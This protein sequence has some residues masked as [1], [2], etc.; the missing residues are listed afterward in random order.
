MIEAVIFDV[1]GVL[2]DSVPS[3]RR[4]R[5]KLLAQY[6]VDFN[7]LPDPH[8]EGH[9]G[10]SMKDLLKA[11]RI[12]HPTVKIDNEQFAEDLVGG[13]RE[14]L[15]EH[16]I[17]ADP[18]LVDLLDELKSH[19]IPC[20]ITSSALPQS[21]D[22]KLNLLGI[23]NYFQQIITADDVGEH[24]PSPASYLLTIQRLGVR[25]E[26]CVIFEDSTPGVQAGVAAGCKVIGF[27]KY[28]S[29]KDQLVNTAKSIGDWKEISYSQLVK[30]IQPK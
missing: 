28:S 26:N 8:G 22:I 27:T 14:D 17:T 15:V 5:T 21:V 24:K 13:M 3:A 19:A 6:G 12:H 29:S 11:V 23:K 9:K 16:G 1:D 30:I 20:A 2:I 25:A 4:L 7:M 10:T 18:S